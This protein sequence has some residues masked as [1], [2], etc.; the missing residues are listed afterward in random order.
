MSMARTWLFAALAAGFL[1]AACGPPE[2][3][4]SG[5]DGSCDP[6]RPR[7]CRGADVYACNSDGT[8]GEKLESCDIDSCFAGTCGGNADCA[9]GAELVYVVDESYHLQSFDPSKLDTQPFTLIG[10]IDCGAQYPSY[11]SGDTA[12][13][14][15][16]SVDRNAVGWVLYSSGELFRVSTADASCQ[17]TGF[18]RGQMGM[19]LFGMGFVS[20]APGSASEKLFISGGPATQI[21]DGRLAVLDVGAL[22]VAPVGALALSQYSPELSGTGAAE[23]YG[24][25]PGLDMYVARIDKGSA[26]NQQTWAMTSLTGNVR[27]WAFAQWGGLFWIFV[28]HESLTDPFPNSQVYRL[29]PQ[30][31]ESEVVLDHLPDMI[32]GAGVSTCA[33]T[34]IL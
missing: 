29:D 16:M 10:S 7:V 18:A 15:S 26:Q 14:Y 13:P 23:L 19:E 25:F 27:A 5:S 33:P 4:G 8:L 6:S 9:S 2:K 34:T 24:Y 28:S 30:T 1:A 11:V 12:Y 22:S 3:D 32:V 20:D 21:G 17:A 31:G